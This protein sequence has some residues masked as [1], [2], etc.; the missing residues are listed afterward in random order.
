MNEIYT[1]II[2]VWTIFPEKNSF[3]LLYLCIS[4]CILL[5][6][7]TSLPQIRA[8]IHISFVHISRSYLF[9]LD[10]SVT[11]W[12][13][14]ATLTAGVGPQSIQRSVLVIQALIWDINSK[15]THTHAYARISTDRYRYEHVSEICTISDE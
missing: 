8:D 2:V 5:L 6:L 4:V 11:N 12:Q 1:D 13:L 10:V 14:L 7:V 15:C 9:I 3:E